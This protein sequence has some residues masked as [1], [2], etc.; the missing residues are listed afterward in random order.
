MSM[1]PNNLETNKLEIL[2]NIKTP[3]LSN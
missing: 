1:T 2:N 3:Y